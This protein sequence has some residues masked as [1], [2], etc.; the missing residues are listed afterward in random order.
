MGR[1]AKDP[2]TR[3]KEFVDAA[4]ELFQDKGVEQTSVTDI[5][6][7]VGVSHGTFFYYYKSKD[8][9][10]QD[11]IGV[12]IDRDVQFVK[13]LVDDANMGAKEKL[14]VILNTSVNSHKLKCNNRLTDYFHSPAN[15]SLHRD[16]TKRSRELLN[17]L[18]T[19]I[20]EQGIREGYCEIQYPREMIDYLSFVFV[21]L[22]ETFSVPQSNE[23]YYR[24]VR[25]LELLVARALGIK[26]PD[27]GLIN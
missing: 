20:A 23:E 25:A 14:K 24:K 6:R 21:G 2:E 12:L 27:L 11:I 15:I 3:R 1:K 22:E 16:F 7:K 19:E 8:E 5:T 17:P 9:V 18:F 4:M 13:A 10:M 26:E